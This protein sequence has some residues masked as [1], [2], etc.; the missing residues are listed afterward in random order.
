[1]MD[2]KK[3]KEIDS[4][5]PC[6]DQKGDIERLQIEVQNTIQ[7]LEESKSI[8]QAMIDA[9]PYV[10]I[11]FNN[12]LEVLDCNP[13]ALD[14]FGFSTKENFAENIL[15][16]IQDSIPPTQPNGKISKTLAQ[17]LEYTI[18]HGYNEFETTLMLHGETTPL[19][20]VLKKISF[21]NTFVIGGYL[22]DLRQLKEA[23]NEL[24]RQDFLLRAVNLVATNLMTSNPDTF[25]Q[26]IL[27]ALKTLGQAV[28]VSSVC[29]WRN[30]TTCD[31]LSSE[32]IYIWAENEDSA[33]ETALVDEQINFDDIPIWQ[34]LLYNGTIINTAVRDL[35]DA[36]RSILESHG[37]LSIL[38]IPIYIWGGFWGFL[39]FDD[40]KK[41][42]I[43]SDTE[44]KIL[45]SGCTFIISTILRNGVTHSL[46]AAKE[47][48]L[49]STKAK[50][51]FLANVSHEIRTPMNAIIG[52]SEIARKSTD[53]SRIQDCLDKITSASRHLLGLINDV[54]DMSKIEA[55]K[56]FLINEPFVFRVMIQNVY[57]MNADKAK[58]KSQQLFV[59]VDERIPESI[60]GD[61]L[62]LSQVINNLISNAIKFT[63]IN[64]TIR[65]SVSLLSDNIENRKI[66]FTVEDN[67]IGINHEMLPLLFRP[68]EQGTT[69]AAHHYGGTGL[70]LA[71]SQNI[72]EQIGGA[73][74]VESEYGKGSVFSFTILVLKPSPSSSEIYAETVQP[75]KKD[76]DFS[77]KTILL[78]EDLEI[79]RTIVMALL[80]QTGV[81]FDCA[82]DGL[83]AY[84]MFVNNPNR[85]N[86][87]YMDMHMP[88][89][90]GLLTTEKIRALDTEYARTIPIIAMT[91]NAFDEDVIAC[92]NAG[93]N[94]HIAKPIDT[95]ELLKKT[96]YYLNVLIHHLPITLTK[97]NHQVLKKRLP[98][99]SF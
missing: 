30:S 91:A 88:I 68:F 33:Q 38:I 60:I 57:N 10:N 58:E 34:D 47:N 72:I 52:M 14:F 80:E 48:A 19:Q 81:S 42:R 61:E 93:M 26:T 75:A 63:Q 36:A 5:T 86:L 31:K 89:M 21:N 71:I 25:D 12:N 37:I 59:D 22:V 16:L 23:K 3:Y 4:L 29:V 85:Y 78:V 99:P 39:A 69:S 20:V 70:G 24:Q 95:D 51:R 32:Q 94:D 79:N 65:L 1:M 41:E 9:N 83:I 56:L 17:R 92:L 87:I 13:A 15:A 2:Q 35:P 53:I 96:S 27:D 46:I 84:D 67:G 77:G 62:R 66:R 97:S 50:S 90:D 45:H 18:T 43:F 6:R 49:E 54:L 11:I 40:Y 55:K 98:L 8:N 76:Y 73:I 44:I 7:K 28:D 64:G 74:E 82:Q